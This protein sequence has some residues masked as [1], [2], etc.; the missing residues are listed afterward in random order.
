LGRH[1]D[2]LDWLSRKLEE[3]EKDLI[4]ISL[5]TRVPVNS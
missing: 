2:E 4:G 1:L 5:M 3:L